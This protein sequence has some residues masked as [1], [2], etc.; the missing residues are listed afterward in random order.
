M[1][2]RHRELLAYSDTFARAEKDMLKTIEVMREAEADMQKC[3]DAKEQVKQ[4]KREIE[5]N[6]RKTIEVIAQ[7]KRLE[8]LLEQKRELFERY[9]DESRIKDQAADQALKA[10]QDELRQLESANADIRQRIGANKDASRDLERKMRDDELKYEKELHEIQQV[11]LRAFASVVKKSDW[12]LTIASCSR[13]TRACSS[14]RS[15][16]TRSCSKPWPP[17]RSASLTFSLSPPIC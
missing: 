5:E 3:K 1:E 14:R 4:Q 12:R 13:C 15:S 6:R 2:R 11:R 8:K 10:A 16:T 9:K 17:S 7:R